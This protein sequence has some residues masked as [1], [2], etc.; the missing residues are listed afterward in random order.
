MVAT[1]AYLKIFI[2]DIAIN[3]LW[4]DIFCKLDV[5]LWS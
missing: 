4:I 3:L 1:K 2:G 5:L